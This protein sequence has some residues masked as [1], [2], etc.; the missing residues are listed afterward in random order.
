VEDLVEWLRLQLLTDER[1]AEA[2]ARLRPDWTVAGGYS[3]T[4]PTKVVAASDGYLIVE[5]GTDW[6]AEI[7][8]HIA[9][10]GP[11]R[12]LREVEAKRQRIK[13]ALNYWQAGKDEE[14]PPQMLA[15][16]ARQALQL[17]SF[18]YA[19]R[20]GYRHEWWPSILDNERPGYRE[21]WK[22]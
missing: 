5:D 21:D 10:H 20:P 19:G 8:Q 1:A 18:P 22:P 4:G 17:E 15:Q 7:V 16:V 3:E 6:A 9:L 13:W 2:V 12:V 11:A 14:G